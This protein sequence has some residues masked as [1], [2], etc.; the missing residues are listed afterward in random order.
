M[1]PSRVAISIA[2]L[3]ATLRIR[4]GPVIGLLLALLST[5]LLVSC[6]TAAPDPRAEL[7]GSLEGADV[8]GY[9]FSLDEERGRTTASLTNP[10]VHDLVRLGEGDPGLVLRYSRVE[11]EDGST[12][13]IFRSEILRREASLTLAVTDL[14]TGEVVDEWLFPD[15]LA[16]KQK[17]GSLDECIDAFEC[18]SKGSLLCQAN[19]TCDPQRAGLICC[20]D[21]G[22]AFSVHLVVAPTDWRCR[23]RSV[24]PDTE[25]VMSQ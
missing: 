25:M 21:D 18:A 20:L 4:P 14:A 23:F 15:G 1:R 2:S 24:M 19:R 8:G 16:C 10:A 13:D 5:G 6:K 7:I 17:F 11:D 9:L 12:S 22:T 3:F